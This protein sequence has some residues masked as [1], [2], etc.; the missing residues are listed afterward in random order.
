MPEVDNPANGGG[1]NNSITTFYQHIGFNG[2][3]VSLSA[4]EYPNVTSAGIQANDVSSIKIENG[5]TV[6][7][8]SELNFEGTKLTLTED[9]ANFIDINFNDMLSSVKIISN[10]GGNPTDNIDNLALNQPAIQSTTGFGGVAS[11]A[12][13]GNT[14]GDYFG[15]NSVTHT[16]PNNATAWWRVDLGAVYDLTEVR[17]LN[18][19]DCCAERLS[20]AMLYAG[21]IDSTCLLYTSPSPRDRQKSRMP[22]SA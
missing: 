2:I 20:G 17:I 21:T 15:G 5:H 14:N 8:Y 6:E 1:G 19:T 10:G 11:R 9:N 16:A 3:A 13:D 4:G 18:R 22:S 7:L 12:V